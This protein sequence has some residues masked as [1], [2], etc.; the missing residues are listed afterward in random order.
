M[1]SRLSFQGKKTSSSNLAR[2]DVGHFKLVFPDRPSKNGLEELD[3]AAEGAGGN[4]GSVLFPGQSRD[5]VN[6]NTDYK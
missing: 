6:N 4:L 3:S 2:T 5:A 1:Q